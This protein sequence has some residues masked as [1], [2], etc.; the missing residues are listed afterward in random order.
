MKLV[1]KRSLSGVMEIAMWG[2]MVLNA[3]VLVALPWIIQ[4]FMMPFNNTPEFW[5]PRYLITLGV[6]GV[7]SLLMLWQI[8]K[9][10]H[11][12]N[13]GTI[14]SK[15]SVRLFK[16][17]GAELLILAV[18]YIGMMAFGG[19]FKFSMG[20]LVLAFVLSGLM[21]FIFAEIVKQATAYKQE[22]DM[23]I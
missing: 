20:L 17:L 23:T 8:R 6:S 9:L 13:V 2:L 14:F 5:F 3:A 18:F 7:M 21:L 22:N 19:M 10:L 11:N 16:W 15:P 12:V 1:G 4:T